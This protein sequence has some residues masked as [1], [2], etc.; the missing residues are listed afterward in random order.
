M[1]EIQQ[2]TN[3][4]S[5]VP[6]ADPSDAAIERM[7]KQAQAMDAAYKIGS[8]MAGTSMVPQPLQGKPDD[9]TAVILYG[10]EIG[11]SAVQSLQ[12]IF[13]VR[14]RPAMYSRTMVAVVLAAGH[15]M[16]ETEAS[17]TSVTWVGRRGD[18]G[19]EFTST[20]TIDRARQ[21]GFTSNKLYESMPVEMLRAKAQAEVARNL[22]P[23]VLLGM[24]HS[25]EELDLDQGP[26]IAPARRPQKARG[27][28]GVMA[29][30]GI[31][32]TDAAAAPADV[33]PK[34]ASAA[35][36]KELVEL[37]AREPGLEEPDAAL[38]WLSDNLGRTIGATK[39]V[40]AD[41]AAQIIGFLRTEQAKDAEAQQ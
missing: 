12:N 27:V 29:A 28:A 24:P 9:C 7:L 19:I 40:T 41:E 14:N 34:Q 38:G 23:D 21:A 16:A 35:Q 22:A 30:L 6:S 36:R 2:Y 32:G 25:K 39:D 15:H 26:A 37:M 11:M 13:V 33:A 3:P 8:A 4:T 5:V 31:E 20:W 18:S 1:T 10:S 17:P